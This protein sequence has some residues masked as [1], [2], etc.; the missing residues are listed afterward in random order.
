PYDHAGSHG[1]R[2]GLSLRRRRAARWADRQGHG[3]GR[4]VHDARAV[5][6]ERAL[7]QAGHRGVRLE[8]HAE[9]IRGAGLTALPVLLAASS[10]WADHGAGLRTEGNPV[11]AAIVWA[12]AAFL[13]GMAIVAIVSVFMRRRP[14]E[15]PDA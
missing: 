10:A 12:A 15:P 4:A 11:W 9:V 7:R 6:G 3:R 5:V 1:R 8:C 14:S 13:V 2:P